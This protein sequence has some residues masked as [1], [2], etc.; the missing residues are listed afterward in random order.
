LLEQ[1]YGRLRCHPGWREIPGVSFRIDAPVEE[2][3]HSMELP[4][5]QGFR[6]SSV[7]AAAFA[8]DEVV[9]LFE[10]LSGSLPRAS[11]LKD[12]ARV[13]A[14]ALPSRRSRVSFYLRLPNACYQF[15][16]SDY[17]RGWQAILSPGFNPDL[18]LSVWTRPAADFIRR[19]RQLM[20][21]ALD[22]PVVYKANH[23][24]FLRTFWK[25]LEL[26]VVQSTAERGEIVFAQTPEAVTRGLARLRLPC[27]PFLGTFAT[28]YREEVRG[29]D[30]HVGRHVP[31]AV[32]YLKNIHH[33]L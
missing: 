6:V 22:D 8:M 16:S 25:F 33:A 21:Q 30:T 32:L 14:K 20:A 29:A 17:F 10:P 27:A 18:F 26:V 9:L 7:S 5:S 19:E 1:A 28:A 15:Y 3:M 4:E 24:D 11:E 2:R 13:H 31:A 23:L 12:L